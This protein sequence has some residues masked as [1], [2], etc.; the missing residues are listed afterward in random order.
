MK[1]MQ[2]GRLDAIANS[3]K[4]DCLIIDFGGV[5]SR[6]GPIDQVEIRKKGQKEGDVTG[7][8]S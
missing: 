3:D 5:V 7:N 1:H 2:Q 6:L 8:Q 4:K